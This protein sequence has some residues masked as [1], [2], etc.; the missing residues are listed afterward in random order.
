QLV[1]ERGPVPVGLACDFIAQAALGL[2]HAHE[3]GMVH[4]DVKP[5]NL[6]LTPAG[7]VKILDFGLARFASEA[8]PAAPGPAPGPGKADG[9]V[10]DP[11]LVLGSVDY[12]A[13]EQADDPQQADGRADVYGLGCTLYFLLAGSPPFA[14]S[15]VGEKLA[16]HRAHRPRP[17]GEF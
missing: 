13:P 4:R 9:S 3:Q 11:G 8:R 16:C 15:S 17:L 12:M 6:M 14:G 7:Q 5:H 1:H 10:T 2:E